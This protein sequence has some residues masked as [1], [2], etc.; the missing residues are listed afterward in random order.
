MAYEDKLLT[1]LRTVGYQCTGQYDDRQIIALVFAI[2]TIR[3]DR[4]QITRYAIK[5]LNGDPHA[6]WELWDREP[7][8]QYVIRGMK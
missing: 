8:T 7:R 1:R 5:P 4:W 6:A 2:W 3:N